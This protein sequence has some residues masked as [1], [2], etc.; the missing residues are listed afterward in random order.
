MGYMHH[1]HCSS[2]KQTNQKTLSF[3]KNMLSKLKI[4]KLQRH[5]NDFDF[6]W[7]CDMDFIHVTLD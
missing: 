2:L 4:K 7:F 3:K 5:E 6:Y 1:V